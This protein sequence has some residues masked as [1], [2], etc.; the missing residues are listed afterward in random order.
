LDG[1]IEITAKNGGENLIFCVPHIRDLKHTL[2]YFWNRYV[3]S[4]GGDAK[5]GTYK[6]ISL[7]L[8][9]I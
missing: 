1:H 3:V 9:N 8:S 6:Y 5:L 7:C 4:T 2:E